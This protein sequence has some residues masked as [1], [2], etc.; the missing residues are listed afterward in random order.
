MRPIVKT[1]FTGLV[2]LG[3][4]A[5]LSSANAA[6]AT[7]FNGKVTAVDKSAQTVTVDGETYQL[8]STTKITK[9]ESQSATINDLAAGK[10]VSGQFKMSAEN[11]KEVLSVDV[12]SSAVGGTSAA[13]SAE[14]GSQFSGRVGRIDTTAQTLTVGGQTYQVLATTKI[15][16]DNKPASLNEVRAGQQVSGMYKLSAE[17]KMELLTVDVGGRAAA[18]GAA[19]NNATSETGATFRG[20][21]AKVDAAAQTVTVGNQ[22]YHILPTTTI[23]TT[24][25][26]AMTLA[27]VKAAQTVSGTYKKSAEGRMELLTLRIAQPAAQPAK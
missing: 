8:L 21:V 15:M 7:S 17:N 18:T 11:K 25:G 1:T 26:T 12:G 13:S 14:A 22:T 9:D 10:Q 3:L 2:A 6:E 4:A 19:Q 5:F 27:N 16:R 23:S 24:D 20:R